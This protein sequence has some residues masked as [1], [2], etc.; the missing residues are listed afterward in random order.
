MPKSKALEIN[1]QTSRCEV[2]LDPKFSVLQEITAEY[3]GL[4]AGLNTFLTEV[5]HP[6]KNW[7]FI[8]SEARRFALHN[9]N[10]F[11]DHSRGPEG[12][13]MVMDIFLDAVGA[14]KNEELRADAI[15][16]LLVYIDHIIDE[17][18]SRL[19]RFLPAINHGLTELTEFSEDRFFIAVK[20][21]YGVNRLIGKLLSE[22]PG[23]IDFAPAVRLLDRYLQSTYE[24]WLSEADPG[25]WFEQEIGRSLDKAQ[26]DSLFG[27]VSHQRLKEHRDE[28]T[29]IRNM[30][31]ES[32]ADKLKRMLDLP[33]F[34]DLVSLYERLPRQVA[35]ACKVDGDGDRGLLI[36]LFHIMNISGLS[37]I[38][39]RTLRDVNRVLGRVIVQ[40]DPENDQALIAQTFRIL[41]PCFHRYPATALNL[42]ANMGQAVYKTAENDLVEFFVQSVVEMGFQTPDLGGVGNDWQVQANQNHVLNIRVWLRLIAL[43]PA[44]SRKLLSALIIHLSVYGVFIKDTDLFPR[45]ITNF[46]NSDVGS[47]FNLV[48]QLARLFPVYFSEIG[49][50]GQLRDTST[51]LDEV[52]NRRDVLIHFLRKQAHVES[53]PQTVALVEAIFEF[54]R[55]QDT[56][57]L[58]NLLPQFVLEHIDPKGDHVTGMTRQ[59][60]HLFETGAISSVRDLLMLA[61]EKLEAQVEILDDV[62]PVDRQRL[63]MAQRLYRMLYQKYHTD[64]AGLGDYLDQIAGSFGQDL[65]PLRSALDLTDTREKISGLLDF[66]EG[67]NS[68]IQSDTAFEIRED[69]YHKRHIA[70][71]IPSMYGS[72]H[73]TKFDCLGLSLRLEPLINTLFQELI[74]GL[75]LKLITRAT[76]IQIHDFLRLFE[77][78]LKLDGIHSDEFARQLDLLSYSLDIRGFSFTQY[79]DILRGVSQAVRN[80]VNDYFN[81]VHHNQLVRIVAGNPAELLLEKYQ[82]QV[83]QLKPMEL[84]DRVSEIFLRDR[85]AASLGLQQLDQFVSRIH[86]TVF[87]QDH[88]LSRYNLR[89]L[90]NYD[91]DKAFTPL[92]PVKSEL[93]DI[94]HLG[95]KGLN[96]VKITSLGLPVPPG[97]IITTEVFRTQ[98]I[99]DKYSPAREHFKELLA[100]NLAELESRSGKKFGDPRNPLLLSVRSGSSISQPGMLSTFLNVGL[101][102]EIVE[103]MASEDSNGAW[104]AWDCYRRFLQTFGMAQGLA[105][106]DFDAIIAEA[107]ESLGLPYKRGF[108]GSQMR[109]VAL[110]YKDYVFSNGVEIES[111]P[112]PQLYRAIKGVFESWEAS[113]AK[114][115]RQ[116]MGI[117]DDWGTAVTVMGMVFGNLSERSGSGVFFTHNP[118]WSGD[119]MMLWGDFAKSNQGEDVV[120]GLVETLP[121]NQKQAEIEGRPADVTLETHFPEIYRRMFDLSER[122]I[123]EWGFGPQE[124][125]FTFEGPRAQDLFF[126]QTRDM[127]LRERRETRTAEP[128]SLPAEDLLGHG[129]GVSG[130]SM[131]GRIVFTLEEI[132][133]WR[134]QEP[135]TNLIL[136]RGDTVPDDIREI[137]EA[138]GLLTARGGSTS[139]AAIVAYRLRK[140]CVVGVVDLLCNETDRTCQLGENRLRSGDFISMDGLTGAV[141]HNH[142]S[143]SDSEEV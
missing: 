28:L 30:G 10:L 123:N 114:T 115:Y 9:F 105:R 51:Q 16:N 130:G 20:S 92:A 23:D 52:L 140:T 4:L 124:L 46:L 11:K 77:R 64:L 26:S 138:D 84:C 129:I 112:F 78:A 37:S 94:I 97:F 39:E 118:R 3:H 98:E 110:K 75:D 133:T 38:H 8:V 117:S 35:K 139:H 17:S 53:S 106:D 137:Y 40:Q 2:T 50:E 127:V 109:E 58:E 57:H 72:Y 87:H 32:Y 27:P 31:P 70:V 24:Y 131:T 36:F 44:W 73:E 71:D 143:G 135:D 56:S 61:P 1:L 82:P 34:R 90:L 54:W 126:L 74:D 15:D 69:I 43:N 99:I 14:T 103:A 101:N 83:G 13:Q 136:V 62:D 121:I 33:G 128:A 19:D 66:L 102:E 91:P 125:E 89:R 21:F 107:K 104:F 47:V 88:E 113:K 45:D 65:G 134:Q 95:A 7:P 76:F 6:Y 25:P 79:L 67:M 12:A 81:N 60:N 22:A 42:V 108:S 85:I 132:E 142:Q 119:R 93:S 116:I 141:Y 29:N 63:K 41:K 48:K 49:A 55:T 111:E 5:C 80:I 96:L 68:L 86:T 120:S 59:V 100:R 122:M 18:D